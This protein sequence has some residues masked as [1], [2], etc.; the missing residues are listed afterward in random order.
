MRKGIA[1][2][3]TLSLL[4][5][6]IGSTPKVEAAAQT[7]REA[8]IQRVLPGFLGAAGISGEIVTYTDPLSI[9]DAEDE[10]ATLT[11]VLADNSLVV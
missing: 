3:L 9:V 10:T 11:F 4:L 1:A 6:L 5:A 7:E 2:I 8:Y